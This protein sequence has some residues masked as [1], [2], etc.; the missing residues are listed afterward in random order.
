[1]NVDNVTDGGLLHLGSDAQALYERIAERVGGIFDNEVGDI[2][3]STL[4]VLAL[5]QQRAFVVAVRKLR[6]NLVAKKLAIALSMC[7]PAERAQYRTMTAKSGIFGAGFHG[8]KAADDVCALA[9][10]LAQCP[11]RS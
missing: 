3:G 4:R 2:L 5:D 11:S 6:G 7:T 8:A 9:E 1:M 10:I